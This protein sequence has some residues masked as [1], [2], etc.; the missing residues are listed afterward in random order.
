MTRR[1]HHRDFSIDVV[2]FRV[3]VCL[4]PAGCDALRSCQCRC[5]RGLRHQRVACTTSFCTT[6][7]RDVPG[8]AYTTRPYRTSWCAAATNARLAQTACA[9]QPV[10]SRFP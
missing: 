2:E 6:T 1:Q 8:A 4:V 5:R 9:A 3:W 7:Q 10:H